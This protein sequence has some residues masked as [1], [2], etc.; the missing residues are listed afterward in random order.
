MIPCSD[1]LQELSVA[2]IVSSYHT[3]PVAAAKTAL[4]AAPKS[5]A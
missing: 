1:A 4:E 3:G 5:A 2:R